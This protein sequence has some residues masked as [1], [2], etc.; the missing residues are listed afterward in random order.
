M[1]TINKTLLTSSVAA[2]LALSGGQVF[3]EDRG[4]HAEKAAEVVENAEAAVAEPIVYT[5][6]DTGEVV[7]INKLPSD[8]SEEEM[9]AYS[10]EDL[11]RLKSIEE[12]IKKQLEEKLKGEI[13]TIPSI[14]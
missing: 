8:M 1:K 9:A 2:L 7:E 12:M 3:A 11:N 5:D 4:D 6:P 13:P 14:N 10:E